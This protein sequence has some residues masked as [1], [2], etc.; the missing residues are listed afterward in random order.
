[1]WKDCTWQVVWSLIMFH[2][3]CTPSP[4]SNAKTWHLAKSFPSKGPV[5]NVFDV[6]CWWVA[7]IGPYRS[8]S[9]YRPD[10]DTVTVAESNQRFPLF[11]PAFQNSST[12]TNQ[13]DVQMKAE[14]NNTKGIMQEEFNSKLDIFLQCKYVSK[15]IISLFLCLTHTYIHKHTVIPEFHRLFS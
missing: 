8:S 11:V 6:V 5:V 13:T 9:L 10:A 3:H 4:C 12:R 2:Q 15:K 7:F 14:G 1:M